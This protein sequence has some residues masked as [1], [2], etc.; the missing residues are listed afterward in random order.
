MLDRDKP[1]LIIQRPAQSTEYQPPSRAVQ[2][3]TSVVPADRHG[4]GSRLRDELELVERAADRQERPIS[5]EGAVEG[6]YATFESFP[7]VRLA[8]E[9]LDPRQGATHPE[10]M[11]VHESRAAD[12]STTE[13]ATVFIPRGTIDYFLRRVTSYL[14]TADETSPK[15]R[16][17][18]DSIQSVQ[19]ATIAALWTDP[20]ADFPGAGELVW[21]EVWL[22]KRDGQE[23]QRLQEF[24]AASDLRTG[25]QSLGFGDRTVTLLEATR[26][27]LSVAI[28]VLDDLA[29]L[30]RPSRPAQFLTGCD[31]RE[32]EEWVAE[33]ASRL[34]PAGADA[35][36]VCV[37]DSG[38]FRE[39]PLIEGSLSP[40][41]CHAA[42]ASWPVHDDRGHGTEMAGLALY[43]DLGEALASQQ[44]I[45]LRH[46]LESAKLL[47]PPPGENAPDLYGALTAAAAST[48]EIEAPFRSR[49]FSLAVTAP[50]TENP[51]SRGAAFGQPDRLVCDAGCSRGWPK[52][53][54]RRQ[55][56][57]SS[58]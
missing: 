25:R 23:A 55:G 35:P 26:E 54:H 24:A 40:S 9:S 28:D 34:N 31:A 57:R 37:V 45:H 47:P 18:V 53:H 58:R 13:R 22:R 41:D 12:G 16:K 6:V 17:L 3:T 36:A 32:Q 5:I 29:E 7:G 2:P 14:E 33:L 27:Q 42:D 19:T 49:V 20:P 30:R 11:S 51:E 4:H 56:P 1:H 52:R 39:H 8:L 48:V 50:T 15:N 21:W 46:R 38:V 43:D 10:L 44:Q